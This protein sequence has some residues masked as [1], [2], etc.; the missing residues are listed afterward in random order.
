MSTELLQNTWFAGFIWGVL[1]CLVIALV[2]MWIVRE[3]ER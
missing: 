3:E 1:A 2:G